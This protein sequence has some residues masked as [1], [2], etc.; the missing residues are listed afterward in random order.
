MTCMK[1][2]FT[3]VS[4]T[5][6]ALLPVQARSLSIGYLGVPL[7]GAVQAERDTPK[8]FRSLTLAS[9][10]RISWRKMAD[11]RRRIWHVRRNHEMLLALVLRDLMRLPVRLVFTSA[12]IRRHSF[13]PRWMIGRMDA[14][15]ATTA[16]AGELVPNV[17]AVVGHGVSTSQFTPPISR[18]EAWKALGL[19]GEYGVGIFGRVREEKGVHLFVRAMLKLLP[20]IPGATAII[21][22]LVQ[23]EDEAFV[24][25]LRKEIEIAGMSSR[26]FWIGLVDPQDIVRWYQGMRLVVACPV[27]EGYGLTPL[28]AMA[29]GC[30]VVASRTGAFDIM[31]ESGVCGELVP[32]NDVSALAVA[33]HEMLQHPDEAQAMGFR[34]RERVQAK[35]SIEA[36]ARGIEAVYR[37]LW[38][39]EGGSE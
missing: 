4:G 36:E 12:A 24:T 13:L 26:F 23:P 15:I 21:G 20:T 3:G 11:G 1:R 31:I 30:P 28:E 8:S 34:A 25:E 6:N 2:R 33:I 39:S 18:S 5:V 22:G 7:P 16:A 29:C 35:F 38:A 27:Y 37:D 9:A 17:S 10:V 19:P 32:V 14:V